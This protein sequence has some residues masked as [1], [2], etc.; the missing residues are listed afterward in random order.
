M[1]LEVE[2]NSLILSS[3]AKKGGYGSFG[4]DGFKFRQQSQPMYALMRLCAKSVQYIVTI[5]W[6][7]R[8]PGPLGHIGIRAILM[9]RILN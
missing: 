6:E 5:S 3:I 2:I 7:N 9:T 1:Y 8:E 4:I